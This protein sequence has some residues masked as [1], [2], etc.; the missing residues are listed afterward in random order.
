MKQVDLVESSSGD[1]KE[2]AYQN[3]GLV[4]VYFETEA[5]RSIGCQ[6]THCRLEREYLQSL[7]AF[8][9]KTF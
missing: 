9:Q 2:Q 8:V 6:E 1:R 3:S 4:G 5:E 7:P